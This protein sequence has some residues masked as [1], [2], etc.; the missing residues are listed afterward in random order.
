MVKV[1]VVNS[2]I[3][4]AQLT[5]VRN[6]LDQG[7][8][9][10]KARFYDGSQKSDPTVAPTTPVIF[11]FA[12]QDPAFTVP[13]ASSPGAECQM[14]GTPLFAIAAENTTFGIGYVRF[15]DSNNVPIFDGSCGT[16][17]GQFDV[18]MT[19]VN[20]VL[21]EQLQLNAPYLLHQNQGPG[22]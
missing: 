21:G 13:A 12:L 19:K 6:A 16:V 20:F 7:A 4:I 11:E 5:V 18:L 10:A 15:V 14:N 8:G 1:S 3:A 2:A 22:G 17:A 9:P